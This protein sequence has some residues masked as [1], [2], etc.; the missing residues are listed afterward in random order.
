MAAGTPPPVPVSVRSTFVE[1][2]HADAAGSDCSTTDTL[3][4][5]PH[6]PALGARAAAGSV[7]VSSASVLEQLRERPWQQRGQ[8]HAPPDAGSP[9]QGRVVSGFT[10]A[11][12]SAATEEWRTAEEWPPCQRHVEQP[13][14]RNQLPR[15]WGGAE[16]SVRSSRTWTSDEFSVVR[17][18]VPAPV[19]SAVAESQH[20]PA[21]NVKSGQ[22]VV[23]ISAS[24]GPRGMSSNAFAAAA[25]GDA[26]VVATPPILPSAGSARHSAGQCKPCAF[27]NTKGCENDSNCKFCHLCEPGEKQRRR[28]QKMTQRQLR[29]T[30]PERWNGRQ[31]RRGQV[32]EA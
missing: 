17:G 25:S 20:P 5:A 4:G 12:T 27:F 29:K 13:V 24:S 14:P 7:S 1:V 31:P 2:E 23:A 30:G 28:K 18:F 15:R 8:R 9:W 26:S 32:S 22:S 19:G 10:R 6:G 11:G 16:C 3:E 21:S